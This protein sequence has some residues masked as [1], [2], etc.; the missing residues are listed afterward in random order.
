MGR[1]PGPAQSPRG[2]P[3]LEGDGL[4]RDGPAAPAAVPIAHD[5]RDFREKGVVL[6]AANVIAREEPRSALP[7]QDRAPADELTREPLDAQP[8][9]VRIAAVSGRSLTLLVCHR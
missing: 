5:P 7:D 9:R 6:A 2:R 4:D 8:L 1:F 3:D